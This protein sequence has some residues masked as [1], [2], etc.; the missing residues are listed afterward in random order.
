MPINVSAGSG[1]SIP[2]HPADLFSSITIDVADL[3]E[4]ESTWNGRIKKV[5]KVM[6]RWFCGEYATNPDTGEKYPLWVNR[7]FTA[8]LHENSALRPFLETWRGR[9][10]TP[11][12]LKGFDLE[13]LIGAPAFIQVS[14]AKVNERVYANVDTCTRL[15]RELTKIN[16]PAGYVRVKDR[17]EGDD[18]HRQPGGDDSDDMPF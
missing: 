14:H 8:S 3:G 15:P 11:E 2:T 5:H 9:P 12:E 17:V 18:N 16:P 1:M 10:F 7:R 4:V 6:I 13:T